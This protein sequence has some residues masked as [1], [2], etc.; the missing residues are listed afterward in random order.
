MGCIL[1]AVGGRDSVVARWTGATLPILG[2]HVSRSDR[3]LASSA[4]LAVRSG[5]SEDLEVI[6]LRH[7]LTVLRLQNNRPT[8]GDEDRALLGAMAAALPD[9]QRAGWIVTPD[10][11]L[12]W[13]RRRI[14]RHWTQPTRPAGRPPTAAENR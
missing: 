4:R 13:H 11:V 12:C 5:R 14:A 8:L 7:Q 10:T 9:S 3:F 1:G 6:V 2:S